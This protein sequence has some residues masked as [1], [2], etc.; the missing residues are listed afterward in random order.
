MPPRLTSEQ[1][2]REL[3]RESIVVFDEAHN[4]DNVAIEALSVNIRRQTLDS[5]QRNLSRLS[6]TIASFREKDALRLQVCSRYP[7]TR[8]TTWM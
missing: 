7:S 3:E 8:H 6:S 2:S 4:I 1:V 5:A